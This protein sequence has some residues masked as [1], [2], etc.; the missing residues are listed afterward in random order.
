MVIEHEDPAFGTVRQVGMG[1]KLSDTPGR[2]RY[3]APYIGQHK[4][5]VL[6]E[7]GYGAEA[8]DALRQRQVVG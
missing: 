7:L 6:G 8:I 4:D 3:V 5:D 1:L 2:V